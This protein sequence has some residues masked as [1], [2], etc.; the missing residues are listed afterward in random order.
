MRVL[1]NNGLRRQLRGHAQVS[2]SR[3]APWNA[4]TKV[5]L[6]IRALQSV[7]THPLQE[8]ANRRVGQGHA[9]S[10]HS[11]MHRQSEEQN[12]RYPDPRKQ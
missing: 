8:H 11:T 7:H 12:V 6:V 1:H 10:E 5:S 9:A 2:T 4:S 3:R